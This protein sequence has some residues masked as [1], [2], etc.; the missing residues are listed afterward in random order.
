MMLDANIRVNSPLTPEGDTALLLA[1]Q[2]SSPNRIGI[3]RRL[4]K[5]GADVSIKNEE[6][7]S[8]LD[9]AE[10]LGDQALE[11]LLKNRPLIEGPTIR[12]DSYDWIRNPELNINDFGSSEELT[13]KVADIYEI[14]GQERTF[15]RTPSVHDLIYTHGPNHLMN[16]ARSKEATEGT[17]KFRWLHLPANNVSDARLVQLIN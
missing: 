2:S 16:R 10:A 4:L 6:D 1:V 14:D 17:R 8:A 7:R 12:K 9:Y 11:T 5:K 3:V 15:L 13:A